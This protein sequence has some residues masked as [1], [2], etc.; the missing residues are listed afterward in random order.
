VVCSRND[1]LNGGLGNDTLIGGEGSDTFIFDVTLGAT[2]IDTI[3]DFDTVED[4]LSLNNLVFKKLIDGALSADN[5]ASNTTGKA[6]DAN[7]FILYN[8]TNGNLSYDSDGSGAGAAVLFANLANKP[9][10]LSYIDFM[11]I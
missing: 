4:M 11:V 2:N 6:I 5:F 10:D 7:D 8:T 3:L 9:I 1:T